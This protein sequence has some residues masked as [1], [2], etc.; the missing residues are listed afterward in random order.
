MEKIKFDILN[1]KWGFVGL[2]AGKS[3]LRHLILP[4]AKKQQTFDLLCQQLH[5]EEL[6]PDDTLPLFKDLGSKLKQYFLGHPV[7]F[8]YKLDYNVATV[9]QR[10]VWSVAR[11]I[12]LG[13]TRTYGWVAE[14]LGDPDSKRAVGQALNA[15]PLPLVVPCHRVVAAHGRLGGFGGGVEM[16]TKLLKLEGAILA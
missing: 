13:Q 9:F 5:G 11:T 12:P 15:N 14:R 16:K 1:T 3:G 6:V 7:E 4:Q 2:A 8:I 10:E